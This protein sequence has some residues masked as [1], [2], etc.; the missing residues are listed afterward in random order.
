MANQG[1]KASAVRVLIHLSSIADNSG[2]SILVKSIRLHITSFDFIG[3]KWVI[4][5]QRCP[6]VYFPNVSKVMHK[7]MHCTNAAL[8]V[9]EHRSGGFDSR[10]LVIRKV[11]FPLL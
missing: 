6:R 9:A 5:Y 11:Y 2:F 7:I 3:I 4:V 1:A 8:C 10:L